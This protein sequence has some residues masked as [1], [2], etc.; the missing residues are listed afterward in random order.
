MWTWACGQMSWMHAWILSTTPARMWCSSGL[1]TIHW[2][3]SSISSCS[4]HSVHN[5]KGRVVQVPFVHGNGCTGW[6]QEAESYF[7][8]WMQPSACDGRD[9]SKGTPCVASDNPWPRKIVFLKKP[10]ILIGQPWF[11]FVI[12]LFLLQIVFVQGHFIILTPPPHAHI[13]KS[14]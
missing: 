3:K 2:K 5:Q 7:D 4:L 9:V 1:G 8:L 11:S 6:W 10:F 14:M 12:A 13:F